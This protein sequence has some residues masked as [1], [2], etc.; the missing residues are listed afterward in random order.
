[1]IWPIINFPTEKTVF[2]YL[3]EVSIKALYLVLSTT[4]VMQILLQTDFLSAFQM[5]LI[6][7]AEGCHWQ[8]AFYLLCPFIAHNIRTEICYNS[9]SSVLCTKPS[10]PCSSFLMRKLHTKKTVSFATP[11]H[12][13]WLNVLYTSNLLLIIWTVEILLAHKT[14]KLQHWLG[15]CK[16]IDWIV[17]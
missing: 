1:M 10:A 8:I 17:H 6:L 9:V 3:S 15:M 12:G 16:E 11:V 7:L 5:H 13:S 2:T 14:R 4:A